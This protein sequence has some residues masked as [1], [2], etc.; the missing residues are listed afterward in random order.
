[1]LF[2]LFGFC[3]IIRNLGGKARILNKD[4]LTRKLVKQNKTV[5]ISKFQ[6]LDTFSNFIG[7]SY[8]RRLI[9]GMTLVTRDS[10]VILTKYDLGTLWVQ[11]ALKWV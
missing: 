2:C 1:M 6:N 8:K 10:L 7:K 5:R 3:F 9:N 11:Y 4:E